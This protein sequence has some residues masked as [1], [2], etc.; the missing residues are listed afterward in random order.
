MIKK[1][2]FNAVGMFRK[3]EYLLDLV[4]QEWEEL[5]NQNLRDKDKLTRFRK[6]LEFMKETMDRILNKLIPDLEVTIGTKFK[7]P[8]LLFIAQSRPSLRNIFEDI[9]VHFKEKSIEINDSQFKELA[10]VGDAGDVLALIGDSVLDMAVLET[11]WDSSLATKGKLTQDKKNLVENSNLAKLCDQL[12][13]YDFRIRALK[14]DKSKANLKT[15]NHEKGT[16]V[17]ALAGVIYLESDYEDVL[18]MVPYLQ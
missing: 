12:N 9:Q 7:S 8:E 4:I 10:S 2:K 18:R 16:L 11:F 14:E 17:E 13:L 5:P 15:I 1:L 6:Q 3:T